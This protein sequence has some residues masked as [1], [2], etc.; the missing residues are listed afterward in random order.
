MGLGNRL[1]GLELESLLV[2]QYS[3]S[4]PFNPLVGPPKPRYD[5]TRGVVSPLG[6]L[7]V[8]RL[9]LLPD[10]IQPID[11]GAP[12]KF[13]RWRDEQAVTF[14]RLVNSTKRVDGTAPP[15]GVG[16]SLIA[17][18]YAR[19]TGMNTVILTSTRGLQDQY[20]QDFEQGLVDVRGMGNYPC[21]ALM[22]GPNYHMP[23]YPRCDVGPCL[24]GEKC[25]W[26]AAGCKYFD[27]VKEG[28]QAQIVLT[29]YAMWL[30]HDADYLGQ[31]NL[32]ICDEAHELPALV[33]RA[34]GVRFTAREIN[35]A[36]ESEHWKLEDWASWA[37]DRI[38]ESEELL[39]S[40]RLSPK[41]RRDVRK[42]K[43]RFERLATADLGDWGISWSDKVVELEPISP[44][45]YAESTLF[46]GA[47]KVV[48]M[49]ATLRPYHLQ[50]LGLGLQD[51]Q[52][53]ETGSPFPPESRPI[54]WVKTVRMTEKTS[55]VN[56]EFWAN[57]IDQIIAQRLDRR[58][59]IHTVSYGRARELQRMS[60][61]R[62]LMVLHDPANA[63]ETIERFKRGPVPAILVSPSIHTGYDFPFDAAEY[64]IISKV[65]FPNTSTGLAKARKEADELWLART[66]AATLVQMAGR[67]VRAEGDQGETLITDDSV[68]WLYSHYRPFFP[69]WFRQA[70]RATDAPPAPPKKI[71]S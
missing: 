18:A 48:L 41:E 67:V 5:C 46:R 1:V 33:T 52:F 53:H 26:S 57:R 17:W 9:T 22:P 10:V 15:T 6:D 19:L 45:P 50:E 13:V 42:L 24:D 8:V 64:Q 66:T 55:Q 14:A 39:R 44:A 30:A 27:R 54:T 20:S 25:V 11:L 12:R 59:I 23:Y 28:Q 43:E 40:S 37:K 21:R 29:N 65:P 35:L 32:V 56:R 61:Y 36:P 71:G 47:D 49:S 4:G 3:I 62:D 2:L 58:G 38:P 60:R 69:S 63:R 34:A 51:Y 31:R 68:V 70:W 16:K 7:E